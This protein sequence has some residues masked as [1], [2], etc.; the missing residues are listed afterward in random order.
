LIDRFL[1]LLG[2]TAN[3]AV[4]RRIL[5][6][7]A[8]RAAAVLD[9]LADPV[10]DAA[11]KTDEWARD[12]EKRVTAS[13]FAPLKH[14]APSAVRRWLYPDGFQF[15][16]EHTRRGISL[17]PAAR[18]AFEKHLQ[19]SFS[20]V[21]VSETGLIVDPDSHFLAFSTDGLVQLTG[22]TFSISCPF[23]LAH[24]FAAITYPQDRS[25]WPISI[26]GD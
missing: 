8:E 15:E 26:T 10:A 11:Q 22:H 16:N 23:L 6:D 25:T 21:V 20:D 4:A 3:L 13:N 9:D 14:G 7:Y 1:R 5:P 24:L 2:K 18:C 12:R 17:E 19:K